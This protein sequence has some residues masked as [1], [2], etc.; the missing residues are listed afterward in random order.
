MEK[1][2]EL[3]D[4]E[5][6]GTPMFPDDGSD[7]VAGD[8]LAQEEISL[9]KDETEEE[10]KEED[11]G[12]KDSGEE[13]T[14]T[15]TDADEK[16]KEREEELKRQ[17]RLEKS[18]AS[19]PSALE[20]LKATPDFEINDELERFMAGV[21]GYCRGSGKQTEEVDQALRMLFSIGL[22][23]RG[24]GLTLDMIEILMKGASFD[25][26]LAEESRKAELRGRNAKI[27]AQMR[28]RTSDDGIPHLESR[29]S[30]G[31]SRKRGIFSL[32][33]D[34]RR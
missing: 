27:E 26:V 17:T 29:G 22:G 20:L 12:E 24:G 11:S 14:G 3:R 31:C 4:H 1:K 33:E 13:V 7:C 18:F 2:S 30:T 32:A 25:R 28:K 15:A 21:E 5:Y 23:C 9:P 16:K 8:D 6:E 10:I 19:F 34:A